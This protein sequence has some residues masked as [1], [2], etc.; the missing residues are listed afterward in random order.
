MRVVYGASIRRCRPCL[1]REQC[2]WQGK[3]TK[4]PRQVSV[5]LHPLAVGNAP[6][7]WCDW[8]RRV[9]RH[10]FIQLLRDQCVEIQVGPPT[11]ASPAIESASLSRAER[12]HSRLS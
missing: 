11:S 5:L 10:A 2:Q 8:S 6:L 12:A 9:H 4:K 1:L 3:T 7:L